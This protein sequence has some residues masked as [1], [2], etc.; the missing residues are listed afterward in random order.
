MTRLYESEGIDERTAARAVLDLA[1]LV[2]RRYRRT[3]SPQ[4]QA[5][6]SLPLDYSQSERAALSR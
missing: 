1:A 2:S 6:L 4:P 5:Q 3:L